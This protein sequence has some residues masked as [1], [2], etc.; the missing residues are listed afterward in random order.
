MSTMPAPFV[1]LVEQISQAVDDAFKRGFQLGYC[2]DAK[3]DLD[4]TDLYT[5]WLTQEKDSKLDG[6]PTEFQSSD[7]VASDIVR[8]LNTYR[9]KD[10][11][12]LNRLIDQY[13]E[14]IGAKP[15]SL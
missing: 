15:D 3:T 8:E 1:S 5:W 13:M 12:E 4:K 11:I 7:S 14:H 6:V 2:V 10:W 9:N